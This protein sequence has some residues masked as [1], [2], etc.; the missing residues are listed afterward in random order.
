MNFHN[1]DTNKIQVYLA[2]SAANHNHLCPRQVLG[3]RLAMAGVNALGLGL[4]RADKRL[5]AIV[6]SDGCFSDGVAAVTGCTV[7]HR[8]LRVEDY[9]KAAVTLV[10]TIDANAF[11]ISPKPDVRQRAAQYAPGE[12]RAYFAQLVGY[13]VMPD[14]ILVNIRPV[15]LFPLLQAL[16]SSP[17]LREVC[18]RCGEEIINER[19]ILKDGEILC[20]SCAGQAYFRYIP[21]LQKGT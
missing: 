11:R 10:D 18:Q 19:H 6:E 5:L 17:G 7:G 1:G 20:R 13:Q 4:P 16:L 15:E 21:K 12:D 8:T 2:A 3:V 14:N 9:G